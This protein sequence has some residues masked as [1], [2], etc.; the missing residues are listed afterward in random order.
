M[1]ILFVQLPTSHLGSGE[2]V[3]PLGLARLSALTPDYHVQS[4]LD[5]NLAR[6]PWQEL[7]L[8]LRDF[9]PQVIALSLR[10]IDPLAGVQA[11]YVSSLKTAVHVARLLVPE[12]AIIAGGA[13]FSLFAE[14]LMQE[15][16]EIDMG[17]VGEGEAAFPGLL[18]SIAEPDK[19]PGLIWRKGD[20]LIHN[21]KGTAVDLDRL[22]DLA[23]ACFNPGDYVKG[24]AYVAAVGIEGKRG[25]DL[26]CGY[27]VYP[28]LGGCRMRLRSP[29]KIVDEMERLQKDCGVNLFH[30]TDS[31]VNRPAGHFAQLCTELIRRDLGISWTGFFREDTFTDEAAS[32]AKQAGLAACYFSADALTDHGLKLLNKRMVKEDVYRAARITCRHDILTMCHFLVNLPFETQS[33]YQEAR[34][35][36]ERILE[37][38]APAGNLGAVIF[39]TIRL[40]PGAP[41]TRTVIREK[42]V[43]ADVNFLYPVYFDPQKSSYRRH[44]LESLCHVSGVL[45][46]FSVQAQQETP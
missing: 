1:R 8:L 43:P 27:C 23:M 26:H 44:E 16:P 19:V 4:G 5:M 3:Y 28:R 46:R 33:H 30:F 20:T 10:N 6:D 34:D 37:I 40:Y 36:M 7:T 41:I 13:A 38:H 45:S 11:S 21:S 18:E 39:N 14:Q 35:T 2:I 22:P 25:C 32:L 17:L 15:I 9:S 12:A 29:K 31:V 24:N 42:L